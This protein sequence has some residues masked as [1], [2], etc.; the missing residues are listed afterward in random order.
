[1]KSCEIK[2]SEHFTYRKLFSF[3]I[4]SIAMMIFLSIYCVVDGFFV[5]NFAGKMEFAALNIVLP[6]LMTVWA[7][8]NS[9]GNKPVCRRHFSAYLF[10]K[11]E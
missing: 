4:P 5:A 7:V 1:M 10:C 11:K 8:G 3:V 2:L 9:N 6:Q